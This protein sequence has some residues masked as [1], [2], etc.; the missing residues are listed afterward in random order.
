[1]IAGNFVRLTP[2]QYK[3]FKLSL[4]GLTE[5]E[6]SAIMKISYKT[7]KSHKTAFYKKTNTTSMVE[8]IV[9]FAK[10]CHG[11][12]LAELAETLPSNPSNKVG[13]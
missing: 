9:K 12:E 4:E 6:M 8:A 1:M 11:I 5:K 7:V 10:E 3:V 2:P 13:K